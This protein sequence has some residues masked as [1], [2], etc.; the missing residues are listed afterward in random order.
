[1]QY[2]ES[3][4][5]AAPAEVQEPVA[6]C[7]TATAEPRKPDWDDGGDEPL[8]PEQEEAILNDPAF[9]AW[10][11]GIIQRLLKSVEEIKTGQV[12]PFEDVR[13]EL[14]RKYFNE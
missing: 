5:P 4:N 11:E 13:R 8:T 7:Y 2:N 10:R 12:Y 1:M 14:R 3:P 6:A 9:I